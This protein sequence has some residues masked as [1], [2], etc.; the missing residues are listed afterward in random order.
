M[1]MQ[2]KND[3]QKVMAGTLRQAAA[4][5]DAG[6]M[7]PYWQADLQREVAGAQRDGT[8]CEALDRELQQVNKLLATVPQQSNTAAA[9]AEAE[10]MGNKLLC[11]HADDAGDTLLEIVYSPA[12]NAYTAEV[13]AD[14]RTAPQLITYLEGWAAEQSLEGT[15]ALLPAPA[16]SYPTLQAAVGALLCELESIRSAD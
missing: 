6:R 12:E 10:A 4:R 9:A 15:A 7:C 16:P 13:F 11:Y 8:W 3:M 5:A 1:D 14:A 2:W